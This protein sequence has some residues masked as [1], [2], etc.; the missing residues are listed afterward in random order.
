MYGIAWS[1]TSKNRRNDVYVGYLAKMSAEFLPFKINL[2][3]YFIF[4][5]DLN[6]S[7]YLMLPVF[8]CGSNRAIYIVFR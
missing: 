8:W 1:L 2:N 3:I 6:P 7:I 4:K 5:T